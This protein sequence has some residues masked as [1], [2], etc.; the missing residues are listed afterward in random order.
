MN[1][2]RAMLLASSATLFHSMVAFAPEGGGDGNPPAGDTSPKPGTILGQAVDDDEGDDKTPPVD[3]NK[4]GDEKKPDD[5][6]KP[7]DAP[8]PGEDPNKSPEENA[9]DKAAAEKAARL[10]EVHGA[11]EGGAYADYTLPDGAAADPKMKAEFDKV[12]GGL[13]L[14]QKGAQ[15]L[16]DHFAK[17]QAEQTERWVGQVKQWG[18]DSKADKEIGGANFA[19]NAG[20]AMQ[21]VETF[22]TPELK[23][24][25]NDYGLG[26]HPEVVRAFYRVGKA[27][28]E[29]S[30]EKPANRPEG[31]T[32]RSAEEVFYGAD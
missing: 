20:I 11:P 8:K 25:L 13:D 19:A 6:K 28:G 1:I 4:P 18:E 7:A 9:K 23:Q 16:V 15:Q 30:L 5:Q 2:L 32:E 3:P 14:S 12:A 10:A 26:N 31:G 17:V 29:G 22:G 24:V 21:A 27:M